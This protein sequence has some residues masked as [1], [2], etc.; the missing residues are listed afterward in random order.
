MISADQSEDE[1][2]LKTV[3]SIKQSLVETGQTEENQQQVETVHILFGDA[4]GGSLEFAVRKTP[5]LNTDGIIVLP[6]NLAVGPVKSLHTKEGID[7]RYQWLKDNFRDYFSEI[8]E[9]RERTLMALEKVKNIEP[10]QQVIIWTSEN[11]AE[12]TGL[13]IVLYLLQNKGIEVSELNTYQSFHNLYSSPELEYGEFSPSTVEIEPE[14]LLQLYKQ[15][16]FKAINHSKCQ[17]LVGEAR[18][19]LSSES[20]L[21]TWNHKGLSHSAED[22]D[23]AFIILCAKRLHQEMGKSDYM[24]VVRLIGE[25]LG[26]MQQYTGDQWIEYRIRALIKKGIFSYRGKL[27]AMRF[28]E[29]KLNEEYA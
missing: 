25:V 12:Q 21:R 11:A 5:Y 14:N 27:R 29:V 19:L 23:D 6:E 2:T 4:V 8:D 17:A 9:D 10:H 3:Q 26:H 16:K 1:Q 28:Y 13:R 15:F 7:H 22:R 24:L 18:E 20:T